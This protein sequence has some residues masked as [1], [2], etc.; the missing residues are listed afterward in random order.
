MLSPLVLVTIALV[1][2]LF[3]WGCCILYAAIVSKTSG[4]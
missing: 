4:E 2:A 1:L 3:I